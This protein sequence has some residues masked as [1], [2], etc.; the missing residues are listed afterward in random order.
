[1]LIDSDLEV[2]SRGWKINRGLPSKLLISAV[3]VATLVALPA[4]AQ[5]PR[6]NP[7]AVIFNGKVI[8]QDPEPAVRSDMLFLRTE[9]ALDGL[10]DR[11]LGL[12][13]AEGFDFVEVCVQLLGID[14]RIAELCVI[15]TAQPESN[16]L[17]IGHLVERELIARDLRNI[18]RDLR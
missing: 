1:M 3:A 10:H 6:Q 18:D 5:A 14:K 17:W 2:N 16:V 15:I 8:G 4:F 9:H 11:H 12:Q 13:P 7:D